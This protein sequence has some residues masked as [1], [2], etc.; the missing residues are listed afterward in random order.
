MIEYDKRKYYEKEIE[1]LVKELLCKCNENKIPF[2]M[3]FGVMMQDG[4]F[5][6]GEGM[7]CTAIL[8]EILSIPSKDACFAEFINILNGA[9]TTYSAEVFEVGDGQLPMT[10]VTDL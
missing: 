5:P 8:P 6:K 9:H 10:E 1:P 2:F 4:K 3:A 7:K